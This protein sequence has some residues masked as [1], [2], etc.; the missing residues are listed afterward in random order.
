MEHPEVQRGEAG[1]EQAPHR[2]DLLERALA[3]GALVWG[4]GVA[5]PAGIFLWPAGSSGPTKKYLELDPESLPPGSARVLGSGG[6]PVLVLREKNGEFRALSAV[7]PHLGCIVHWDAAQGRILCP[8]HAGVFA[9]DGSVVSGPPP[10]A[11]PIYP[12][13]VVAGVLRI[14]T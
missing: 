12:S 2:R 1:A 3:F 9:A 14:E 7:C 10:R 11:L 5:I 4:A 8:C 6:K 13:R